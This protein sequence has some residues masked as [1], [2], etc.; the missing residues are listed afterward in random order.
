LPIPTPSTE[1]REQII[2]IVRAIYEVKAKW[3]KGNE[4]STAFV[5]PW[6]L[7]REIQESI[8]IAD[9]LNRLADFEAAEDD[10]IQQQYVELNNHA[11]AAYGIPV[12]TRKEIEEEMG[13]RPPEVI[14]P[15][16]EGKTHDQKRMD[17]V[18]R[19]LSYAVM[20]VVEADEDGLVPLLQVSGEAPL[21]DRVHEELGKMFPTRDVNEVE[22]EIVNELKRKVKGYD[23]ADSIRQWL[24]DNYFAYHASM[25]KNRP[26]FWHISSKQGKGPAAFSALVH[27]HRFDKDRIAKLRG[28]YLREAL[29]VFRREAALAGQ[30]GRAD[31]QHTHRC[32]SPSFRCACSMDAR[33]SAAVRRPGSSAV[34][35]SRAQAARTDFRRR[36]ASR[37]T[38]F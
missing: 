18:W 10:R 33:I 25:Y 32:T 22:V 8:S 24:E 28:V 16:M 29:G 11:Y 19:L 27:Y 7:A 20:R 9:G 30:A 6:L 13:Q 26:I 38:L 23:R 1:Q 4:I 36:R 37:P 3:D 21:L 17:H 14:W 31:G 12:V 2:R 15:Q 5:T 35:F 34:R